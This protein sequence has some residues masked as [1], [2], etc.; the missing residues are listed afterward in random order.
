VRFFNSEKKNLKK[1]KKKKF[2]K[3]KFFF[4]PA[5]NCTMDSDCGDLYYC[6]MEKCRFVGPRTCKSTLDC[7]TGI[8]N[9][10]FDCIDT[11]DLEKRAIVQQLGRSRVSPSKVDLKARKSNSKQKRHSDHHEMEIESEEIAKFGPTAEGDHLTHGKRCWARKS[12][13]D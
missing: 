11:E 13:I 1:F 12:L 9:V 2:R 6:L 7:A 8:S 5:K 10:T 4:L 3:K